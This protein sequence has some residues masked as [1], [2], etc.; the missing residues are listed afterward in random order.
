M[1]QNDRFSDPNID[2][3]AREVI[4]HVLDIRQ[5]SA[6]ADSA[7]AGVL[8]AFPSVAHG[9]VSS[10]AR[11]RDREIAMTTVCHL[12]ADGGVPARGSRGYNEII[13]VIKGD[14]HPQTGSPPRWR[15]EEIQRESHRHGPSGVMK[16][17]ASN[18]FKKTEWEVPSLHL[19]AASPR[20]FSFG[21]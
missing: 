4:N 18:P 17:L 20:S 3:R 9:E 11:Q 5:Q 15:A 21:A 8:K 13:R 7:F 6:D 16:V 1:M 12:D 14:N 19:S 10:I 2:P